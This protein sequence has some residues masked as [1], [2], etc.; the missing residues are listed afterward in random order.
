MLP[1]DVN[2]SRMYSGA[3]AQPLMAAAS[4]WKALAAEL[5]SMGLAYDAMIDEL[6]D[7]RVGPMT[8]AAAAYA[9]WL[10]TTAAQAG[11]AASAARSAAA[12][13]DTA[14]VMTV[15]PALVT[16]NRAQLKSLVAN[17]FL[18][19]NTAAIAATDAQYADMWARD[20]MAMYGYYVSS[21]AAAGLHPFTQPPHTTISTPASSPFGTLAMDPAAAFGVDLSTVGKIEDTLLLEVAASPASA[22]VGAELGVAATLNGLSV[23][24]S[25]ATAVP[26]R[27]IGRAVSIA[28]DTV[29]RAAAGTTALPLVALGPASRAT[30]GFRRVRGASAGP[31]PPSNGSPRAI[32]RQRGRS[33]QPKKQAARPPKGAVPRILGELRELADP[34]DTRILSDEERT[35]TKR[36]L[37]GR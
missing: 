25:W 6:S 36:R 8:A 31:K 19:H 22:S 28:A 17:N 10:H 12:A 32:V 13:Y 2:S 27:V 26:A 29:L 30:A 20:A 37:H 16:A 3:G 14:F 15:P 33:E 34:R 23:P 35:R 24:Q 21:T 1:P 5:T 9:Q 4:A 18:G 11:R 7:D